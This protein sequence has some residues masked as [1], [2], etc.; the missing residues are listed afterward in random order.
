MLS[1]SPLHHRRS[2][3]GN[4]LIITAASL[5]L[6]LGLA[7][8]AIDLGSLLNGKAEL[9]NALDAAALAAISQTRVVIPVQP[10]EDYRK[11]QRDLVINYAKKF[12]GLNQVRQVSGQ[13]DGSI[14]L[15]ENTDIQLVGTANDTSGVVITKQITLSTF[16]AGVLGF[17][18]VTIGA[19][20]EAVINPVNGGTGLIS[21]GAVETD[22]QGNYGGVVSGCWRPLIIPD[23]YFIPDSSAPCNEGYGTMSRLAYNS[24][25]RDFVPPAPGAF[26]RSRFAGTGSGYPYVDS[27]QA[28]QP[29]TPGNNCNPTVT[30]LRD[31]S[32]ASTSTTL[33][34][35]MGV[36]FQLV[37]TPAAAPGLADYRIVDFA[38]SGFQVSQ[39]VNNQTYYG[40]CGKVLVRQG[41]DT[42]VSVLPLGASQQQ[43]VYDSLQ[44]LRKDAFP[45]D[46]NEQPDFA[47][48]GKLFKFGY[49]TSAA[50]CTLCRFK[51]PNTHPLIIPVLLCNPFEY[52]RKIKGIIPDDGKLTVTNI[53]ALLIETSGDGLITGRFVREVLT[54]GNAIAPASF[55]YSYMLP[56]SVRLV[57]K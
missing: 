9:Q 2:E 46:F 27:W 20:A 37:G 43:A 41:Q 16:F 30:G 50:T 28:D 19:R 57:R 12:A 26:Y 49:I 11:E 45:P 40:F 29:A 33:N 10:R 3:R 1:K 34:N 22:S 53:G 55:P 35:L 7:A 52:Y 48:N 6:I 47:D 56:A 51:T 5:L 25:T 4:V 44:K 54:G 38:A 14:M 42:V 23:T 24:F 31:A 18:R 13:S 36:Q 21:G 39:P 15:A 8:L 32:V 17:N